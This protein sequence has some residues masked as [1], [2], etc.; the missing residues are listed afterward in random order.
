MITLISEAKIKRRI[1]KLAKMIEVDYKNKKPVLI[2]ILKGA[3]VFLADLIREINVPIEIDFI[4]VASYYGSTRSSGKVRVIDD[5]SVNI[6]GRN[7]ILVEDIVDTGHTLSHI[8]KLMVR[9]KPKSLN[10]CALFN[11]RVLRKVNVPLRYIGFD[12]PDLFVVGYG[13]DYRNRH[14]NLRFLGALNGRKR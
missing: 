12:I 9:R 11:K 6:Q 1:K 14:R 10:I 5:L 7:V 13:L 3:V 4:S 8:I 2:G